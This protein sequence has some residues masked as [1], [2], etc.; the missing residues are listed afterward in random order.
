MNT[1][2]EI[3]N[4]KSEKTRLE[5]ELIVE[6]FHY[7][8]I[9]KRKSISRS[10]ALLCLLFVI[11]LTIFVLINLFFLIYAIIYTS[12]NDNPEK[13][14]GVISLFSPLIIILLGIV[15]IKLWS[16]WLKEMGLL[17]GVTKKALNYGS[18]NYNEEE[19]KSHKIIADLSQKILDIDSKISELKSQRTYEEIQ[20]LKTETKNLQEMSDE[21]FFAYAYGQW[22]DSRDDLLINMASSKYE[23]ETKSINQ[24]IQTE[25]KSLDNLAHIR[26]HIVSEYDSAK[27][28]L[29]FFL[30]SMLLVAFVELAVF[31]SST[32]QKYITI[33]GIL[34]GIIGCIY[35][36]PF[37]IK[38]YLAYM[39][40]F[41]YQKVTVYAEENHTEPT[42]HMRIKSM[43]KIKDYMNRLEYLDRLL[44]YKS[45][46]KL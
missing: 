38:K 23:D 30:L 26:A 6:R 11:P 4:L 33:L 36:I 9:P 35:T 15:V 10:K 41:N 7:E 25:K 34:Y 14:F 19:K 45:G 2:Y 22:G 37:F 18:A 32:S 42:D 3:Y 24:R 43:K 29:T 17:H 12:R 21:E 5:Y 28:R 31:T 46:H 27:S 16:I 8:S 44:E 20:A 1:S 40:E 13:I 39:V